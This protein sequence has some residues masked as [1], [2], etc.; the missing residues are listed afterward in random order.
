MP[1]IIKGGEG[2]SAATAS[3]F[4]V[5]SFDTF[6]RFRFSAYAMDCWAVGVTI[7]C[8][9]HG[10]L[11]FPVDST[12]TVVDAYNILLNHELSYGLADD[13]TYH[14]QELGCRLTELIGKLLV[15]EPAL[16]ATIPIALK[17]LD[18]NIVLKC[19]IAG[20]ADDVNS[21]M[22]SMQLTPR[23]SAEGP[24][25]RLALFPPSDGVQGTHC[26]TP[27]FGFH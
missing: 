15:R 8:F 22:Y 7:Y 26:L 3:A 12:S 16:R 10:V 9:M 17:F 25:H 6:G 23:A 24:A 13:T 21:Y 18:D 2:P 19:P 14:S 4:T 11:P 20:A 5:S 1:S 27:G